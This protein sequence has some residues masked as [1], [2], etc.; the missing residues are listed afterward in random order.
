M[1]TCPR[2][3]GHL[4]DNHRCPRRPIAVA[5]EVVAAALAGGAAG[6]LLVIMF[7]PSGHQISD[8]ESA[9]SIAVGASLAVG[10]NRAL[11]G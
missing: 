9:I 11:R 3:K 6:L 7:D 4:T 10:I 2:C 1:S 8:L 5:A